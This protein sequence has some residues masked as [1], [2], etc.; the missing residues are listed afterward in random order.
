[1]KENTN[2]I[3]LNHVSKI[4]KANSN[5][6]IALKDVSISFK[7]GEFIAIVGKSGSGKS[8][9]LNMIS[10]I[11]RPTSG[12]ILYEDHKLHT[13]SEAQLTTWRAKHIGIVFQFFQLIPTLTVLE[14]I[15]LPMDFCNI[16]PTDK[17]KARALDLLKKTGVAHYIDKLPTE[18]SGGEQQRV[19]IARS[20][21]NDPPFIIADEPTGNLDSQTA[22]KI[23]ELFK[24]LTSSGK[25]II[26]V[27]HSNE[28]AACA[29]RIITIHDGDILSDVCERSL[30]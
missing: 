23:I 15:L 13:L 5:Q 30:S 17:R 8:T 21:A 7:T 29:D 26:M 14:N 19:A 3:I 12:E 10:G 6:T 11:D 2:C 20:L 16:Y 28:L 24:E 1:M 25:T 9:L 27:T 22:Q 18:L 4:Y